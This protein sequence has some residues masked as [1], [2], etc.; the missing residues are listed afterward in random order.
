MVTKSPRFRWPVP[1]QPR[2][3]LV[4]PMICAFDIRFFDRSDLGLDLE[5]LKG[6]RHQCFSVCQIDLVD[7]RRCCHDQVNI[8]LTFQ[9]L[10][11]NVH[12]K[13]SQET[14]TETKTEGLRSFRFKLKTGIIQL[15]F[16]QSFTKI[17]VFVRF[18]WVKTSKT[19]GFICLY[20]CSGSLAGLEARVTVSP[21]RVSATVLIEAA[22]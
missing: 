11:D 21:T 20:P 22:I 15:Q 6:L 1:S 10:L 9:A 4:A 7:Y 8:E 2:Q 3:T 14:T 5:T 13:K 17:I 12:M 18:N 16:F 19:I